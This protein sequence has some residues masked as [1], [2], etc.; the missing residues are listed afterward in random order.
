MVSQKSGQVLVDKEPQLMAVI[1]TKGDPN[2]VM[3]KAIPALY[4]T[5]YGLKFQ[6]KKTGS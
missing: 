6:L 4:G 5:G 1:T 2:E 3:E